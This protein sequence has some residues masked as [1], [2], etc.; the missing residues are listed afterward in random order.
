[1]FRMKGRKCLEWEGEW[2]SLLELLNFAKC[3][4]TNVVK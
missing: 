4:T 3:F 1:M 2:G